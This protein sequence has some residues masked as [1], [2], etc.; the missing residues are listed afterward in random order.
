MQ[1]LGNSRRRDSKDDGSTRHTTVTGNSLQRQESARIKVHSHSEAELHLR[2]RN[3][4]YSVCPDLGQN[5]SVLVDLSHVITEGMDTYPG[6]PGP[7]LSDFLSRDSSGERF[8]AIRMHIGKVCMITNT[9]TYVDVP[10]H[11]YED[12]EHLG[13]VGIERLADLPAVYVDATNRKGRAITPDFFENVNVQ[14]RAVLVHTGWDVH[15]GKPNY[16]IDAP[17][18]PRD[19]VELLVDRG[20]ALVGI[21]SVNID[22]LGDLSRPAHCRLLSAGTPIVEHLTGLEQL[23]PLAKFTFTAAPPKF[24]MLGTFPVRAFAR[25]DR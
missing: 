19:T 25:T 21:D 20:V 2:S 15:F 5:S 11:F 18:L 1:L 7:E 14:G 12:G 9:G 3:G 8:G 13:E 6:I 4:S 17:F 23:R 22:D 16:A 24:A 10:F